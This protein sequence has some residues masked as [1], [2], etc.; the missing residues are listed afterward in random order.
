MNKIEKI[1]NALTWLKKAAKACVKVAAA[2]TAVG[3]AL[4]AVEN[5]GQSIVSMLDTSKA[6]DLIND[7]EHQ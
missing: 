7:G 6:N 4:V 2:F 5:A 1:R 3:T